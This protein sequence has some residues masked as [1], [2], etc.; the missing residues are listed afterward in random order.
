MRL[1]EGTEA[2]WKRDRSQL[3]GREPGSRWREAEGNPEEG[4]GRL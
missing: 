4:Q 1:D 2:V 3:L